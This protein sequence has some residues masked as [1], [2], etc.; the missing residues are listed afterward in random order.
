MFPT[1]SVD[2]V[3]R[4]REAAAA[5]KRGIA[6]DADYARDGV[7][8]QQLY[9][10]QDESTA[11]VEKLAAAALENPQDSDL[12]FLIGAFL[13]FEGQPARAGRFFRQAAAT[14]TSGTEHIQ[15]FLDADQPATTLALANSA[16]PF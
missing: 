11:H 6:V 13:H 5:F 1:P 4:Y 15:A 3:G 10:S 8:L 2:R 16:Q 9:R 14:A 7:R 12:M